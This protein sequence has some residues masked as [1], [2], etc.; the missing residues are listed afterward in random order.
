MIDRAKQLVPECEFGVSD[1]T[2][3]SGIAD[4]SVDLVVTFTVFQHI[5]DRGVIQRYVTEIGRVLKPGGTAFIQWNATREPPLPAARRRLAR[6]V[7]RTWNGDGSLAT[8]APEFQGTQVPKGTMRSWI[9][10]AGL[11][12][13]AE[14]G[15]DTLWAQL[16]AVKEPAGQ[17][18]QSDN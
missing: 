11:S 5:P 2:T 1:G 17:R 4:G 18:P 7:R 12:V 8:D 14:A 3:L 16:W 15:G 9:Q 6:L 13:A 10:D